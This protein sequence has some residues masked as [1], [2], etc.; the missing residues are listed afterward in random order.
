MGTSSITGRSS[1]RRIVRR[2]RAAGFTLLELILVLAILAVVVALAVPTL[3]G[4]AASRGTTQCADQIVALC[5]WARTQSVTR[6]LTYRLNL[7]AGSGTYWLTVEQDDGTVAS[8][9]EEFGRVF[10]APDGT[11]IDWNAPKQKDGQYVQ[12]QPTGRTDP[13]IV[14]V[15]GRDNQVIEVA[16]FSA[17]ELFHVVTDQERQQGL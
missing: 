12:F 17:T 11:R 2:R 3:H 8:P 1:S 15:T 13:A 14:R 16:C 5:R 7:D 9:G 4:F 6:G 10:R